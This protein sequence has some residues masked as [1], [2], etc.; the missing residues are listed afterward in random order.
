MPKKPAPKAETAVS[1]PA[2][3]AVRGTILAPGGGT[4]KAEGLAFDPAANKLYI[5]NQNENRP[6]AHDPRRP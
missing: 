6:L 4:A 5:A 1:N 2:A 3:L